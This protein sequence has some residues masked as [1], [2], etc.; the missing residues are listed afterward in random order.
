[1]VCGVQAGNDLREPMPALPV[2]EVAADWDIGDPP[3]ATLVEEVGAALKA[4]HFEPGTLLSDI[5]HEASHACVDMMGFLSIAHP[6]H[7][8]DIDAA[9]RIHIEVADGTTV[10]SSTDPVIGWR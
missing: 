4:E 5:W 7:A 9:R 8:A 10:A 6:D 3:V 2:A 1:M